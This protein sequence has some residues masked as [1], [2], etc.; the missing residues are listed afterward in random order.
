MVERKLAI[1]ER[2]LERNPASEPLLAEK[3]QLSERITPAEQLAEECNRALIQVSFFLFFKEEDKIS[4]QIIRSLHLQG[5][6]G[7]SVAS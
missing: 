2:A 1:L 5:Y 7:L 6:V 4:L 3:L